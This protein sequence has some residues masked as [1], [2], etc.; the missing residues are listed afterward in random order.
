MLLCTLFLFTFL[1]EKSSAYVERETDS[2]ANLDTTMLENTKEEQETVLIVNERE[3]SEKEE[4]L[5]NEKSTLHP[6]QSGLVS[7]LPTSQ[8]LGT[9]APSEL[10]S[11]AT[12]INE[13]K[14][15]ESSMDDPSSLPLR[16]TNNEESLSVQKLDVQPVKEGD[17]IKRA[18]VSVRY[19]GVL[20]Q[21]GLDVKIWD[22]VSLGLY[23]GR[24]QGTIAGNEKAG[25][26]PDLH[27]L[28]LQTTVFL[29]SQKR[30]FQ[31]GAQLRFGLHANKQKES[32]I[33]QRIEVDGREVI[34]PGQT[35]I[36]ALLG[37]GY[38]W[39]GEHLNV[40]IGAEY[41]SLGAL[42]SLIPLVVSLGVTF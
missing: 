14:L 15:T 16:S 36:G 38:G 27:H 17:K 42:K 19:L 33:V 22:Q 13:G 26:I 35:R 2:R 6:S 5:I 25:M 24:F 9:D 8:D 1:N 39:Y 10:E 4:A 20:A 11:E 40:N 29:N 41:L 18:Q 3:S 7:S 30:A 34:R 21:A 28:N 32:N 31:S 12:V 37:V 23:Y